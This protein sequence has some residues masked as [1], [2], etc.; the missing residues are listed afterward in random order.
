MSIFGKKEE[1]APEDIRLLHHDAVQ[2]S[3]TA[4]FKMHALANDKPVPKGLTI[5]WATV[6]RDGMHCYGHLIATGK[7][8]KVNG[9]P[10]FNVTTLSEAKSY[11]EKALVALKPYY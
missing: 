9:D 8:S 2:A 10:I 4:Y 3:L 5:P 1:P 6:T 7:S 11:T